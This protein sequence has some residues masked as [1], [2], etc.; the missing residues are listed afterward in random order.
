VVQIWL[1]SD[2]ASWHS[3]GGS[4]LP[5]AIREPLR[6]LVADDIGIEDFR[7]LAKLLAQDDG[8]WFANPAHLARSPHGKSLEARIYQ[9]R[10]RSLADFVDAIAAAKKAGDLPDWLEQERQLLRDDTAKFVVDNI[11]DASL[12]VGTLPI[13]M[14]EKGILATAYD[15][16]LF[17][18]IGLASLSYHLGDQ[19]KEIADR[20]VAMTWSLRDRW[21]AL[22]P[23]DRERVEPM[24]TTATTRMA[25]NRGAGREAALSQAI[26]AFSAAVG[27]IERGGALHL[28]LPR[29]RS[30]R[31][32]AIGVAEELQAW[33]RVVEPPELRQLLR[34]TLSTAHELD[35]RCSRFL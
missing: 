11:D 24:V 7:G 33:L 28:A 20:F 12:S 31:K 29:I 26:D 35:T 4:D 5:D 10:A 22:D 16:V 8:A 32:T 3:S 25:V 27:T 15:R 6:K 2:T 23:E 9:A 18:A 17:P 34:N 19:D 1:S 13:A 30:A 21:Q 14:F